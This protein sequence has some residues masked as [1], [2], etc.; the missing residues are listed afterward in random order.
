MP[1]PI[2]RPGRESRR[3][4]RRLSTKPGTS[5]ATRCSNPPHPGRDSVT[6][7]GFQAGA[8]I[9]KLAG[10]ADAFSSEERTRLWNGLLNNLL[11]IRE[12]DRAKRLCRQIAHLQ[13]HDAMIRYRLFELALVTHDPRDPAASLAE[14]DR[15]LGKSTSCRTRSTVVVRQG[16]AVDARGRARQARTVGRRHGLRTRRKSASWSRP[17]VLK[18]E[19]CR[20]QGNNEDALEHYLQASIA[21]DQDLEFIRL[22][23]QM[24]FERQ[25]YQEAE[26]VIHRLD[27]SQTPMTPE[28]EKERPRSGPW[29][30]F[31][32]ALEIAERAYNPDPAT[33]ATRLARPGAETAGPRAQREGHPDKL[34]KIA[35]EAEDSFRRA[36]QIAPNAAECRVEL[37]QLLVATNQMEKARIAGDDAYQMISSLLAKG[38]IHEA[39]GEAKEAG[40]CYE[41]AVRRCRG[42][43]GDP[44]PGRLLYPRQQSSCPLIERFFNGELQP[45]ESD[46]VAARRMKAKIL[47]TRAMPNSRRPSLWSIATWPSL[48]VPGQ[49]TQ[50]RFAAA[51]PLG[52]AATRRSNWRKAWWRPAARARSR[53]PLAIGPAVLGPRRL[54]TLPGGNGKARERQ[55]AQSAHLAIYV[56]ML[57]DQD[58]LGDAE[59]SRPTGTRV[60]SGTRGS[61][62]ANCCIARRNG[63]RCPILRRLRQAG[64]ARIKSGETGSSSRPGSSSIL[65]NC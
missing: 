29:G 30:D 57:L 52:P 8:E 18:G 41:K 48:T 50:T 45:S 35:A 33:T 21:G 11:E 9:E 6:G 1:R 3:W 46:L 38:Y 37:V 5:W 16:G 24:L 62:R 44:G 17:H 54:G 43:P 26:Q 28:I 61:L 14:L 34:P 19:I 40:Q 10:N 4:P 13:P 64:A 36:C 63:E 65:A 53:R 39:L 15:V 27:S 23:L 7:N 32:R 58:L 56:R 59:L 25:R 22:L 49:A 12:Y 42:S 2:W 60:R 55:P 47:A 31:D 20:Q 51:D